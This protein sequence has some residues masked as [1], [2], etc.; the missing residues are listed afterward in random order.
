MHASER[1]VIFHECTVPDR[2][3]GLNDHNSRMDDPMV[4]DETSVAGYRLVRMLGRGARA[5]VYLGV[6]QHAAATGEL[7]AIKIFREPTPTASI[8]REIT[9]L[10]RARGQHV[11][12]LID[13]ARDPTGRA[14]IV[15]ERVPGPTVSE[16]MDGRGSVEPGEAVTLLA[17]LVQ[18]LVRLHDARV[19]HGGIR[20]SN[21]RLDARG[22]PVFVG[23]GRATLLD[24]GTTTAG[25]EADER[26]LDDRKALDGLVRCVLA[27]AGGTSGSAGV[28]T[29]LRGLDGMN[30]A[31]SDWF[32]RLIELLF[33]IAEPLPVCTSE[34]PTRPLPSA[35]MIARS[36]AD[37]GQGRALDRGADERGRSAAAAERTSEYG[38]RRDA[39]R[40]LPGVT[41]VVAA[42]GRI[43]ETAATVRRRFWV[44]VGAA[45]VGLILVGWSSA[46]APGGAPGSAPRG[47]AGTVAEPS[48][49]PSPGG[50][51]GA[52]PSSESSDSILS[53]AVTGDD[54]V[55][56]LP[57][58]RERRLA[59]LRELSILCLDGVDHAG[60]MAMELDRG[61]ILGAQTDPSSVDPPLAIPDSDPA[62]VSVRERL[63]NAAILT[64][65]AN[66]EPASVLLV[67][68]EAGWRVREVIPPPR[69]ESVSTRCRA[70]MRNRHSQAG[71]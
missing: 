65:G 36:A 2:P 27:A 71:S 54:P 20:P 37:G 42:A 51:S 56:A 22:A 9:A 28:R 29:A 57:V 45:A 58:L 53:A 62:S 44:T 32:A 13:V 18:S 8:H 40:R 7:R 33:D 23:F 24:D 34:R 41:A 19:A 17:P 10:D 26:V 38:V 11:V 69:G 55:A 21:V 70:P 64:V 31:D 15:L 52:V 30:A 39:V 14:C 66:G 1:R 47:T 5:D 68:G 59:C 48:W 35:S 60:S 25:G 49:Q 4:R 67:K 61:F 46:S 50:S 12:S 16:L 6:V 3:L 43:R 63:G